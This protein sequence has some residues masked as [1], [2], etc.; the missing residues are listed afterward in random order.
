MEFTSFGEIVLAIV[1]V[2]GTQKGY[3]IYKRKRHANGNGTERRSTTLSHGDRVFFSGLFDKLQ[4][5]MENDRLKLVNSVEAAIR[6]EG[7]KT[8][9]VVRAVRS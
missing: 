2:L 6:T 5:G 9:T 8:R 1:G 3:E 7:E 4:L